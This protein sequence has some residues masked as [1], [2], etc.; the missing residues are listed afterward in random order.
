MSRVIL[1]SS[2]VPLAVALAAL[3]AVPA[4][5]APADGRMRLVTSRVQQGSND[6]GWNKVTHFTWVDTYAGSA[7]VLVWN[8]NTKVFEPSTMKVPDAAPPA[9]GARAVGRYA[10]SVIT[11]EQGGH[12]AGWTK[13]THFI[14]ADSVAGTAEAF[15]WD[16]NTRT[17]E[18]WD[19]AVPPATRSSSKKGKAASKPGRYQV[20]T[21][22]RQQGS[23]DD[24]WGKLTHFVWTDTVAGT[25]EV[26][27]WNANAK[28]FEAWNIKVPA[29]R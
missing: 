14:W 21:L 8:A 22:L 6:D 10:L 11:V 19:I 1:R 26:F 13:I 16:A 24:G 18:P 4:D 7:Q 9:H 28:Q 27:V 2:F 29:A 17:F 5:A 3:A 25:A 15:S 20:E 23:I 12:D